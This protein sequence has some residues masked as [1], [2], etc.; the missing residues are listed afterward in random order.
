MNIGGLL[1]FIKSFTYKN[2]PK[3]INMQLLPKQWN[4]L[5]QKKP[6]IRESEYLNTQY[7][8]YGL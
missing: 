3:K 7:A 6:S 4:I 2:R 8:M 5:M 1:D